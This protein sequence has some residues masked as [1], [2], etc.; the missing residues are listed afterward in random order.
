MFF[1]LQMNVFVVVR[2][3]ARSNGVLTGNKLPYYEPRVKTKS[4]RWLCSSAIHR[5]F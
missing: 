5:T 1:P 4:G 3:I 2:F